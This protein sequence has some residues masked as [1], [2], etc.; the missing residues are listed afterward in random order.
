MPFMGIFEMSSYELY[1]QKMVAHKSQAK[2]AW[3]P[4]FY[5]AIHCTVRQCTVRYRLEVV[6]FLEITNNSHCE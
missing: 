1:M 5:S 4:R 6:N 2:R 3:N